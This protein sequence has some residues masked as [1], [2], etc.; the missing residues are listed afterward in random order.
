MVDITAFV[1]SITHGEI[2][3]QPT[4]LPTA[5]DRLAYTA[6]RLY[7]HAIQLEDRRVTGGNLDFPLRWLR[8]DIEQAE[9]YLAWIE[10][11]ITCKTEKIS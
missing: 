7:R 11:E 6:G 3:D 5:M 8:N 4:T 1:Q 9:T 2:M 10:K